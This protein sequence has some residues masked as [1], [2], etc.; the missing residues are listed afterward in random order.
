MPAQQGGASW[1]Q[2]DHNLQTS[3]ILYLD[4]ALDMRGLPPELLQLVP[5]FSA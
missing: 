3:G 5:L 2:L 4:L 1:A